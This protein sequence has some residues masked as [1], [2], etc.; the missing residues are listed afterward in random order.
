MASRRRS[1]KAGDDRDQSFSEYYTARG[2]TM[3][4]TAYL[5]CGNWHLAED[6]TQT[7]FTKLY[8][9]WKRVSQ[10]EAIDAYVRQIIFR[11]FVDNRR[12]PWRREWSTEASNSVFEG[13]TP[14]GSTDDRLV[15]LSALAQVP[16]R[17]RAVLVLRF[18]EDLSVAETA[19]VL[20]CSAGT[21]KSHSS[22]GLQ[23]LRTL[24]SDDRISTN[25]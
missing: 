9:V 23:T 13:S 20:G 8:R 24:L 2:T 15:L 6:L 18:W 5:L 11:T 19:D 4:A 14:G 17:Q 21:V 10:Y 22:R 12:R 16:A 3:R 1:E 7:A 25:A